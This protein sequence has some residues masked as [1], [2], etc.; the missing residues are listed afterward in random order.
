MSGKNLE[1][2]EHI[3][4]YNSWFPPQSHW[5]KKRPISQIVYKLMNQNLEKNHIVLTWKFI[6]LQATV[7]YMPQQL[8]CHDICKIMTWVTEFTTKIT[9]K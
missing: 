2:S 9:V 3:F 8:N 7:L 1:I 6:I 4:Q 5:T